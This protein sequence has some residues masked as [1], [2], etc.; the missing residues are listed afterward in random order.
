MSSIE[1]FAYASLSLTIT[2]VF[3][4]YVTPHWL[5]L[6]SPYNAMH[7][8]LLAHCE[9]EKCTWI[10]DDKRI[11]REFPAWFKATQ[12]LMSVA[13][14]LG[15]IALLVATL[16]LCCTCHSCN[17]HHP[18]CGFLIIASVSIAVAIVV[19]GIKA[20]NEWGIDFQMELMSSGRFGWSF[21]TAVGAAASALLTSTIYCCMDRKRH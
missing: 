2:A 19:F 11:S 20:K 17:P 10:L 9:S 16:S 4:S 8:G 5:E 3:I 13:L 14:A 15:L 18:I 1:L 7:I 6:V 21:W 12:G